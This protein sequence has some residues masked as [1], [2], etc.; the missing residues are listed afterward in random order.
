MTLQAVLMC[1]GL[2]T[3]LRPLT[4]S[5]PKPLIYVGDR[6]VVE[7]LLERLK[8]N[9]I[10]EIYISLGYKGEHIEVELKDGKHL[11]LNI[12][13]VREDQPLGTA[14]A[15]NLLRDKLADPFLMMNGDLVT[16][17][18]F[19]KLCAFHQEHNAAITVATK[20]YEVQVPYGVVEDSD[21][22]VTE[23]R[24]KPVY[25][26]RI[27]AGIYVLSRSVLDLL[28]PGGRFDATQLIQAALDDGRPV[29]SYLIEEYWLDMGR[30]EDYEKANADAK[31]WIE[32]DNIP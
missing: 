21:G 20:A 4:Y 3:R 15:L 22:K 13:Y 7:L 23:L 16:R 25:S 6:P 14:G 11:G 5:I 18:D 24:E 32:E 29:F 1:G 30:I 8:L 19:G 26:T 28:P 9:G 17:L 31:R 27:N 10:T 2:G 12:Q